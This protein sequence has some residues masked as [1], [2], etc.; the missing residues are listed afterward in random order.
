MN[1]GASSVSRV[2]CRWCGVPSGISGIRLRKAT[3]LEGKG[4]RYVQDLLCD[5]CHAEHDKF[6]RRLS[7]WDWLA[8]FLVQLGMQAKFVL[9]L[10]QHIR[11][12]RWQWQFR[13]RGVPV[14]AVMAERARHAAAPIADVVA[15]AA[16]EGRA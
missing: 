9:S 15:E 4:N 6:G 8:I 7:F 11:Q 5:P 1:K 2:A 14:R 3:F 16:K 12:V 13:G 10:R